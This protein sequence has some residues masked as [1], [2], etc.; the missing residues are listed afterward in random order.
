MSNWSAVRGLSVVDRKCFVIL[1]GIFLFRLFPFDSLLL[2]FQKPLCSGITQNKYS[3]EGRQRERED[4]SM[5]IKFYLKLSFNFDLNNSIQIDRLDLHSAQHIGSALP[6]ALCLLLSAYEILS[7]QQPRETKM[8]F[9]NRIRF[10][11]RKKG[12]RERETHSRAHTDTSH[13]VQL[14]RNLNT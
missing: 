9:P 10:F 8:H 4:E 6:H 5:S 2:L 1:A 7:N 11:I 3:D 13:T 14:K 12:E